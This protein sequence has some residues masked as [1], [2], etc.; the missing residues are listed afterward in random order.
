MSKRVVLSTGS[1]GLAGVDAALGDLAQDASGDG[2]KALYGDG[3]FK[4]PGSASLTVTDGTHTIANADSISVSGATVGGSS[5]NATLTVSGTMQSATV[6]L[7]SAQLLAL[8][9]SPVTI[10]PAPGAGN[11]ILVLG[12]V[13]EFTAGADAYTDSGGETGLYF[14]S[15]AFGSIDGQNLGQACIGNVTGVGAGINALEPI[16]F[17]TADIVNQ[18]IVAYSP[19]ANMTGGD[20]TAKITVY[21]LVQATDP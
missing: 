12:I 18:G 6:S 10:V 19:T 17:A 8:N 21:Y 11:V 3:T 5:P 7:S 14:S 2:T 1:G 16:L 9:S 13:E 15:L 4:T 20:G